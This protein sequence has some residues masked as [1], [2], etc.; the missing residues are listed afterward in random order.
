MT[1]IVEH[2]ATGPIAVAKDSVPGA[3]I[4]VCQCGLSRTP[5]L[6]DGSH[7]VTRNETP[8]RLVRY[9]GTG[10][11][12]VA[13]DVEVVPNRGAARVLPSGIP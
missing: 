1:R 13:E 3:H 5:P 12:L 10:R 2:S 4:H 11:D 6:C 8:G 7:R 9:S